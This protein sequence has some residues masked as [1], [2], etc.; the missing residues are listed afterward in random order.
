MFRFI[1]TNLFSNAASFILRYTT[2]DNVKI[3]I[4]ADSFDAKIVLHIYN[5]QEGKIIFNKPIRVIRN[6]AFQNCRSMT[7]VTIPNSVTKIGDHAFSGCNSLTA[8]YGKFA[9]ADNRCLIVNGVLHTFARAEL[10][11]YTIPNSVTKIGD[12]AFYF[13]SRLTSVTIPDSVTEIGT[14]AFSSCSRLT[15]FYGKFASADNRC[16]IV[17]GVL[18]TFVRAKLTEYTIPDSVTEIGDWAFVGCRSLTSITIPNS[19]TKIG[20]KA[21]FDCRSLRS[22]T[23]PD[24]VTEI[25][26]EAFSVCHSLTSVTI[27]NSITKIGKG[28]FSACISLT[29]VTIPDSVTEI[30][31]GAFSGCNSLTSVTIPDS[32]TEIDDCTFS[33]CR[34]LTSITIPD[35]V[36]EIGN[37]AF[38]DCRSLT[39][40]TIPDRLTEIGESAFS[41]CINMQTIICKPTTPP[42]LGGW[43]FIGM[44]S[45]AT[46][47]I[48]EGCEEAYMNSDWRKGYMHIYM[49]LVNQ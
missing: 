25:G 41:Y 1:T 8:F 36:T 22:V 7:S 16:L 6:W 47:I 45:Y 12:N 9:S 13:C 3:K 49:T 19:V 35:S 44:P 32:V 27:P 2:S 37:E 43:A 42:R 20:N 4:D 21:F 15:A 17:N 39:N 38:S 48:P 31:E 26:N 10:T 28:A 34:S 14:G 11:E 33:D 5:N 24:S 46:I 29:N 30:G 23:I 40:V 18:H